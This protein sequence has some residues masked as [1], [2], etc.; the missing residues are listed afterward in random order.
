[1]SRSAT[2]FKQINDITLLAILLDRLVRI[3]RDDVCN[4]DIDELMERAEICFLELI[5]YEASH[6][7][8]RLQHLISNDSSIDVLSMCQIARAFALTSQGGPIYKCLDTFVDVRATWL[9][10]MGRDD[11]DSVSLMFWMEMAGSRKVGDVVTKWKWPE[12][13]TICDGG[14]EQ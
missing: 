7:P 3:S 6:S 2:F 9:A 13:G 8:E 11:P 4:I 14:V 5:G 12:S 10:A 1:M